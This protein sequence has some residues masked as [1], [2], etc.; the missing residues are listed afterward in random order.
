MAEGGD[1]AGALLGRP[2]LGGAQESL[3]LLLPGGVGR[4][5]FLCEY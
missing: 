4:R 2:A 3:G 5:S 1:G